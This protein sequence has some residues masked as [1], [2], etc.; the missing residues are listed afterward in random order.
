MNRMIFDNVNKL[1]FDV[2]E[3]NDELYTLC[4]RIIFRVFFDF[5]DDHFEY[6]EI[7]H[8]IFNFSI[9][10]VYLIINVKTDFD[11]ISRFV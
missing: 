3:T 11:V 4:M 10:D 2:Y 8:K 5:F 1:F 7:D 9:I 6:A